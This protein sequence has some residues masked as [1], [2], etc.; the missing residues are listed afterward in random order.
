MNW[1]LAKIVFQIDINWG[2]HCTQ[3]DESVRLVHAQ[4]LGD[5]FHKAR[6]LGKRAEDRF[7]NVHGQSV[8]W[9]FIDVID[10]YELESLES[11]VEI[12]SLT[13][14]EDH[15]SFYIQTVKQRARMIQLNHF[16]LS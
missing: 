11:G 16:L 7:A 8:H 9:K 1:Y 12:T 10:V 15:A 4:S 2:E 14:E 5:A 6:S 3:F 13:H